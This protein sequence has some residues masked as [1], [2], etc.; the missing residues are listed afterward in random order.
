M[1]SGDR[2]CRQECVEMVEDDRMTGDMTWEKTCAFSQT[3][4]P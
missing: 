4:T 2:L 1:V 3:N